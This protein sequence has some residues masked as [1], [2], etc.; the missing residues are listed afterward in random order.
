MAPINFQLKQYQ[1]KS[2]DIFR[3]YLKECTQVGAKTA[4]IQATELPYK[5]AP[6]IS[7]GT[8]YVCLRIPTGGGKTIMAA[9]AVGIAAQEY[10]LINN[11]MVLWLVPS[12]SIREQTISALKDNNHPYRAAL[13]KDFGHNVTIMTKD[14]ALSMSRA[15]AEGGACI[16]VSTIQSFRRTAEDGKTNPEGLKVYE[17]AGS[18]MAHFSGLTSDQ[19]K[20]LHKAEGTHRPIASLANVLR[21]HRPMVIVDEAHNVRTDLSFEMLERFTP[22]LIL[23]LTAT[24]ILEGE[25]ASNILHSVSAA[26]LKAE[27][28]IK[29]PIILATDGDWQRTVGSALDCQIELEKSAKQEQSETGEYIRPIILFQAQANR[30]SDPITFEKLKIFLVEDKKIPEE[31][32]AVQTG[33]LND[34]DDVDINDPDCH[35]RYII[36]VQKLKEGWDCPFAYILCSI[37]DQGSSTAVEQILGRVLRMPK[38]KRKIKSALNEAYAFV[39]SSNFDVA[40]RKLKDGLI[41]GAGFE[42][43]EV[44]EMIKKPPKLDFDDPEQPEKPK[45]FSE[46][47]LKDDFIVPLLAFRHQDELQLFT[48]DHFLNQPWPLEQCDATKIIDYFRI[49][50]ET[51][52]GEIDV[53]D[54]GDVM[55]AFSKRVQGDLMTVIHEPEWTQKRL[56]AWLWRALQ[57]RDVTRSSA[58]PFFNNVVEHLIASGHSL[59]KLARY[60]Y[61]LRNAL[62]S[63]ITFLRNERQNGKY[64]ALFTEHSDLFDISSKHVMVFDEQSYSYNQPYR[65]NRRFNKHYTPVIGDLKDSGEEFECACHIDSMDEVKYWIRNVERQPNSFWLQ[66]PTNKFYPDFV[67][68]L[69]DGRILVIEYK[70]A[71]LYERERIKQYIGDFWAETS[72][73]KCLFCMPT[74]RNFN[75]INQA[76]ER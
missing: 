29:M 36:T 54:E 56:V 31:Q 9:N 32:I 27:E 50:D 72:E 5:N 52:T 48:I 34:L 53:T 73:G 43:I 47:G 6:L 26:E 63:Y 15:D 41:K 66:L 37:T 22:S 49:I 2:L 16:I 8:P 58:V 76:I 3:E 14:E 24:P 40:A 60:K 65:G 19:V 51:R 42:H 18:L 71:H 12:D 7:E 17:D 33:N 69:N 44:E 68:L 67:A 28:M 11:P 62:R 61:E 23:E 13:T 21:L 59:E 39:A 74:E 70:G 10:L 1:E 35:I 4:F 25:H 55:I 38:A 46:T 30:G 45:L 75:T 64:E 20:R 57:N